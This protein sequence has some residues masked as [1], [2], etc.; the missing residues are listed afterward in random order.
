MMDLVASYEAGGLCALELQ[1]QIMNH[2][3]AVEGIR[4][5]TRD[6]AESL[7]ERLCYAVDDLNYGTSYSNDS[8]AGVL[9]DLSKFLQSL[10]REV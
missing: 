6:E 8:V 9:V 1:N 5:A 3:D 2:M 4:Q 7:F 10:P